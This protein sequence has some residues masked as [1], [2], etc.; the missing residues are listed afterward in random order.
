MTTNRTASSRRLAILA[1]L[2]L[3]GGAA[4]CWGFGRGAFSSEALREAVKDK[5]SVS[6]KWIRING[7][8]FLMGSDG[9]YDNAL[10]IHEVNIKSF[11]M[12]ATPVTVEQYAECVME[13]VCAEPPK[14]AT[15]GGDCNWGKKKRRSH[16][17]NC[18]SWEQANKYAEF[19]NARLP[20][21]AEYEYAARSG[22]K[23][24]I[25]P[26]GNEKPTCDRVVMA[27]NG[28]SA[29]AKGTMP[30]CSRPRGNTAQGLCDMAGNILQWVQD[31]YQN[32]Y[33]GAPTDGSALAASGSDQRV[34]RSAFT[35]QGIDSLRATCRSAAFHGYIYEGFG[36]RLAR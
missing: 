29:C 10:P 17:I 27:G 8:K 11:E 14:K 3:F 2:F 9:R 13:G 33:K 1:G 16:P 30:V 23:N 28:A 7:G 15:D 31:E 19:I 24:Q 12:S 21:E 22:G 6:I 36:F 4:T 34:L 18:V 32:S 35:A 5:P 25:Y 26:W 20:S